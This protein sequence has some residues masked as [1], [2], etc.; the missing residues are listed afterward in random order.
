MRNPTYEFDAIGTHWWCELL[1]TSQKF[2]PEIIAGIDELCAVFD[3]RYSRFREDSLVF[4]L[5]RTGRLDNP[6]E[7]MVDMFRFAHEMYE[8][9]GGM[10]DIAV[11]ATLHSL[12]YGKRDHAAVAPENIWKDIS[13]SHEL[14]VAPQSVMLDFGGQGKGWLID[15]ISAYLRQQRIEQFI[16]N[17]GGDMFVASRE[18]IAVGLEDPRN[19]TVAY[20]RALLRNQALA[21]SSTLK[22]AWTASDGTSHHHIIDP[23]TQNS[24]DGSVIGTFVKASSATIADA[25]AT[26][27]IIRPDLEAALKRRYAIETILIRR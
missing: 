12:G 20:G 6:P 22:R 3:R 24:S 7:D 10:F 26:V 2:T 11:G 1:D 13:Y 23:S 5:Y 4:E 15:Q 21:A 17:G 9:T 8:A 18:P 25:L 14:I 16:V 27:L 19:P